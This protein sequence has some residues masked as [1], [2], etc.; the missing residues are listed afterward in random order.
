[1]GHIEKEELRCSVSV[2]ESFLANFFGYR[3]DLRAFWGEAFP[4]R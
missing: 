3:A 4:A 2:F 1:M